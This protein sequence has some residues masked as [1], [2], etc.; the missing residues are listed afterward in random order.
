[1]EYCLPEGLDQRFLKFIGVSE[2]SERTTHAFYLK[3]FQPGQQVL[4]LGCGAGYFVKM[5]REQGV[6]ARGV[7]MDSA[8]IEKAQT[9]GLP[10]IQA[11]AIDYLQKSPDNSVDAI[12]SAHLVEH[13]EVEVVYKLIEEAYR[14]L[15]PGGFLLVTTPNVRA[16]ISHL[17]MFWL[18]FDH[19][20][21]YHPRLLEFLM[22]ECKFDEVVYGENEV[23]RKHTHASTTNSPKST[24]DVFDLDSVIPRPRYLFMWPWWWFKRWLARLVVLP[25]LAAFIPL[26]FVGRPFEVYV[27]GSKHAINL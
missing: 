11:N 18:H 12:F 16:L 20:R 25:Y 13:L 2:E 24:R 19:K 1:M 22:K 23:E 17:E 26:Q 10:V 6:E 4:D 3:F 8:A 27:I 15:K 9:Q 14:T 21:F 5:L 7:D